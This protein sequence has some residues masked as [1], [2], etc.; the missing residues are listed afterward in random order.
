MTD[1]VWIVD[2]FTSVPFRGNPA[3][4]MLCDQFPDDKKMQHIAACVNLSETAFVVPKKTKKNF[5]LRWFT[6]TKEVALCG[7]ATLA[8]AHALRQMGKASA[9]DTIIFHTL[10]GEL[11]AKVSDKTIELDFPVLPGKPIKTPAAMAALGAEI[12]ACEYNDMD[13]LVEV[14]DYDTLLGCAP[15]F[16][17]LA[18]LK[19]RGIIVTTNLGIPREYDF[20]SRFF[21]PSSG[22]KEDPVTG[23]AHCFLAPYWAN[24]LGKKTFHAYQASKGRG[25]LDVELVGDRVLISGSAVTTLKGTA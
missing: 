4:V 11:P 5:D 18:K 10:S 3:G 19:T 13:Y 22:I 24:K 17:K 23:S 12:V 20:A 14:E 15:D 6:P 21:A 9:G 25:V 2:A 8:S 16:K 1:G 7:H